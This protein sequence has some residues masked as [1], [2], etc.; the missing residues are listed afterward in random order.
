[1]LRRLLSHSLLGKALVDESVLDHIGACAKQYKA[2]P[3]DDPHCAFTPKGWL[4]CIRGAAALLEEESDASR[5][6]LR[7]WLPPPAELQRIAEHEHVNRCCCLGDAGTPLLCARLHGERLGA[8]E[9]TAEVAESVLR[10]EQFNEMTRSPAHRL[11]GRAR[12]A[13]GQ[14]AA[15]REAAESAVAGAATAGYVWLEMLALRDLLEY[16]EAADEKEGVRKRLRGVLGRVAAS[17]ED[18]MRVLGKEVMT[19]VGQESE[20]FA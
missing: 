19:A 20:R 1:M 8:W 13:L 2:T 18:L 5:N 9:S 17:P 10:F 16:T 14:A 6:A 11:L 4:L 15:A 3:A 12:A 7:A